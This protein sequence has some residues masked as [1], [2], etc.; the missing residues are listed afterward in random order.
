MA[1]QSAS[2]ANAGG[3]SMGQGGIPYIKIILVLNY[4]LAL[5]IPA[6]AGSMTQQGGMAG[7]STMMGQNYGGNMAGRQMGGFNTM[8]GRTM[9]EGNDPTTLTCK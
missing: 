6:Q 2:L 9:G 4:N 5:L 7:Q 3:S 1:G 8:G